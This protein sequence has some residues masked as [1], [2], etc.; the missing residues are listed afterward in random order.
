MT[1][2]QRIEA[3]IQQFAH[4]RRVAPGEFRLAFVYARRHIVVEVLDRSPV[5]SLRSELGSLA[6]LDPFE[7]L[8][9][10]LDAHQRVAVSGDKY[11]LCMDLGEE[12]NEGYV[13]KIHA[14]VKA[15]Q[16]VRRS[17]LRYELPAFSF[18]M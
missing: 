7:A 14:F 2:W 18:A 11:F 16:V 5:I 17:P 10:N 6:D 1:P 12:P 9:F 4:A 13:R 8:R 3:V 15:T